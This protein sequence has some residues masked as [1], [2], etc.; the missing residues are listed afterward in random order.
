MGQIK[1]FRDLEIWKNGV[2]LVT[3]I[4]GLSD[5]FPKDERYGL[6]SQMRRAAVSVP[7][8]VAEGFR[9]RHSG[10]FKQFLNIALGSLAEL[11]TQFVIARK[12]K[13]VA[14]GAEE[15][16]LERIDHLNRMIVTLS[17]K[18]VC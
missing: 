16:V 5:A 13:Y 2:E 4:Y 11:E 3:Q 10:E 17:K 1:S 7:S 14:A 18:V 12:L 8:N 15:E 9:R 6:I